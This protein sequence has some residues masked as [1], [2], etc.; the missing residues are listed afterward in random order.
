MEAPS[1]EELGHDFF[2]RVHQ[3]APSKDQISI[4]NRSHYGDVLITRVHGWVSDVRQRFEQIN[5]FEKLIQE[6]GTAI[7]KFFLH[8]SKKE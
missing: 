2:W 7:L 1:P 3:K 8:I 6:G 5:A 4:F